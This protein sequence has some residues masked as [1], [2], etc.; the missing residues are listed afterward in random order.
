[1]IV[2]W[3]GAI[4]VL[5]ACGKAGFSI[6]A[7]CIARNRALEMLLRSLEVMECQMEYRLT[8]LPELCS[9]L[10]S[11]CSG[12]VQQVFREFGKELAGHTQADAAVCMA[13]AV[14]RTPNLPAACG[15]ILNSLA[16]GFSSPDLE[17]QLKSLSYA[18][19]RVHTLLDAGMEEQAGQVKSYRALGLCGGAALAILLL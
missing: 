2:R 11:A 6:A 4:C 15:E 9:I 18:K 13:L 17:G 14:E 7:E 12:P 10:T 5:G 16:K 19:S 8:E 3:M 1:M